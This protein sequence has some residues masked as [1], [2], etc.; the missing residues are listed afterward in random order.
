MRLENGNVGEGRMEQSEDGKYTILELDTLTTAKLGKEKPT[1]SSLMGNSIRSITSNDYANEVNLSEYHR[2]LQNNYEIYKDVL[3]TEL[4]PRPY[5]SAAEANDA[6]IYFTDIDYQV[7]TYRSLWITGKSD[8]EKDW[9]GFVSKIESLQI[10]EYLKILQNAYDAY[11][12]K[13]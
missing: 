5:Y 1:L 4:W 13:Q 2:T 10:E 7:R 6:D 12:Q 11:L 9:N 8:I 3:N